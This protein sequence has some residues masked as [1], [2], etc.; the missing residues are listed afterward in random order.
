MAKSVVPPPISITPSRSR[1]GRNGRWSQV[2]RGEESAVALKKAPWG[3]CSKHF[4]SIHIHIHIYIYMYIYMFIYICICIDTQPWKKWLSNRPYF[5]DSGQNTEFNQPT[6]LW[7]IQGSHKWTGRATLKS[8]PVHGQLHA[9]LMC[10]DTYQSISIHH[11]IPVHNI[12]RSFKHIYIC[13]TCLL[14]P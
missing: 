1:V 9:A 13:K 14:L 6:P 5:F 8:S 7:L 10:A 4:I 12:D 11:I 2:P 3:T